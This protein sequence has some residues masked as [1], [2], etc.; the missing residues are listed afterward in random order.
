MTEVKDEKRQWYLEQF[1]EFESRLNGEKQTP[2]HAARKNALA[3]FLKIGFPHPKDEEWRF[4][5]IQPIFRQHFIPVT[6]SESDSIK[7]DDYN[8]YI[9]KDAHLF[10]VV[11]GFFNSRLSGSTQLPDGVVAGSF[12]NAL[13]DF[14]P[15]LLSHF[16]KYV[17][18]D[19]NAFASL[20]AAFYRDGFYFFVPPKTDNLCFWLKIS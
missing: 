18:A 4:T 15:S 12:Q 9:I 14:Q 20:N 13:V 11:D 16:G 19:A 3:N 6:S 8:E 10:V 2:H 1:E 17:T 7:L 5:N